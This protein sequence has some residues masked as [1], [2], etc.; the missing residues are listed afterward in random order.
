MFKKV[1][2]AAALCAT[3]SF[4]TWNWFP[5][6][7]NHKGEGQIGLKF[8]KA[9]DRKDLDLYAGVRYT[10]IPNLELGFKLPIRLMADMDGADEKNGLMADMADMDGV[11][12][13]TGL[14]NPTFM[15]RYQFMPTMNAFVDVDLPIGKEEIDGDAFGLHA[16]VQYSQ[17]F[18]MVNLGT[19]L[20]LKL[21]S[22]GD[23]ETT[24][25]WVLDIGA[26]ADFEIG[27]IVTPFVGIELDMLIGKET[28][29][30]DNVGESYTG[31]MAFWP[32]VGANVVFSPMFNMD[33]FVSFGFGDDN[34][35]ESS[36]TPIAV[37]AQLNIE[38]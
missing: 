18:G 32:Y 25:P 15:A 8:D 1:A 13:E 3:A 20:G 26:E 5:V 10:V 34:V 31:D 21:E 12:E 22:E 35:K 17:K 27:G 33:A 38:F 4:A 7:E 28:V 19:E 24:P 29:D 36:D 9:G 11:D 2:L 14:R 37:N 23:D 30:G 6:L 16:G